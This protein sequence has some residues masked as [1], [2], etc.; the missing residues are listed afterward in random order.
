MKAAVYYENGPPSVFRYE[1]VPDPVAGP[2]QVLV[3]NEVITIEGGDA[4]ARRLRPAPAGGFFVVGYQTGGRVVAV[5]EGASRFKVGDRVATFAPQG[6]HAALR[7]VPEATAWK[8]PD[9]LDMK[10][11]ANIP[12]TFG[13]ADDALFEFGE[14]KAGETVLI[15]G[16]TGG[17]GV[18]AV[19]LARDAGAT[20][21]ATGSGDARLARLK[22][23]GAHHVID[24]RAADIAESVKALTGGQGAEVVVEM[25]GGRTFD[26]AV[27]AA[28]YR[29][30]IV[31]VG[32]AS[33]DPAQVDAMK[34]LIACK[35]VR[36]MIFGREMPTE[37]ARQMI[38]RHMAAAEAGRLQV[39]ID[40][41]F[42]LSEAAA[43]HEHLENGHPFGRVLITP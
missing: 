29:G 22:D 9:G 19:Q 36:G 40:R 3:A 20:V 8:V 11:G 27:E 30:R 14:L 6:S 10:V 5:G 13:T 42:P 32:A 24:Y 2:G 26:A 1:D 15:T 43:A 25:V 31:F 38:D 37:R 17:V 34:L 39:P 4:I 12:V 33:G 16:A 18:A 21:I 7:A 23:L 28:A 41:V 35:S